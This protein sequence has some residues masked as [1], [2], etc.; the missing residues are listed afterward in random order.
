MSKDNRRQR[1][2]SGRIPDNS[3]TK[4]SQMP[5]IGI[6]A[7]YMNNE[8]FHDLKD[9]KAGGQRAN[10]NREDGTPFNWQQARMF[11]TASNE[12]DSTDA[13][14]DEPEWANCGPISKNDIIELHGFDG[15]IDDDK[16]SEL[17]TADIKA[18]D[19]LLARSTP[20]KV[21]ATQSSKV[22]EYF[23]FEEFLKLDLP[24]TVSGSR[25]S[26]TGGE[27][28]FTQWFGRNNSPSRNRL[29]NSAFVDGK[30]KANGGT[31]H[32]FNSH[33]KSNLKKMQS[34]ANLA[35]A[36]K[37]RSVEEL[38]A[39]MCPSQGKVNTCKPLSDAMSFQAMLNRS[40]MQSLQ[41]KPNANFNPAQVNFLLNLI[42]RNAEELYQQRLTKSVAMQRPDAQLMLHR[43][44][45]GELTQFHIL[46]Q[47]N[48]PTV[49]QRDRE[50]FVAVLK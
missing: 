38:E 47:I 45:N 17:G 39:N 36:S 9:I 37:F 46:Q 48:N 24:A 43:L 22:D 30:S 34:F 7:R 11:D 2:G 26:D 23:N 40:V 29:N 42:N 35:N 8:L 14:S 21:K 49:H 50:T 16:H 4:E 3:A 33:Q 41:Q 6:D 32:F 12:N 5:T 20:S 1:F 10:R 27:S 18:S 15:P 19:M 13:K 31:G 44:V 28:R 25:D